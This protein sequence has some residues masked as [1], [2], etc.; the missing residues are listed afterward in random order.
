MTKQISFNDDSVNNTGV[1]VGMS[2]EDSH[3]IGLLDLDLHREDLNR[4]V[5]KLNE[6]IR[7]INK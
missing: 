4:V 7:E 3:E 1:P 2:V 6:V 5:E